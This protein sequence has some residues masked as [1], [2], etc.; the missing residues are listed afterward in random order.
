MKR[1]IHQWGVPAEKVGETAGDRGQ[2]RS[3]AGISGPLPIQ[4]R[5]R[6]KLKSKGVSREVIK[7]S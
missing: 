2:Q 3:A 7:T 4:H 1:N 6:Y 5:Q